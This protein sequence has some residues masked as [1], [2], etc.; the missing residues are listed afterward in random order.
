VALYLFS[1]PLSSEL[2]FLPPSSRLFS[3]ACLPPSRPFF[4]FFLAAFRV[5]FLVGSFFLHAHLAHPLR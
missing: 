1:P 3:A 4:S 5:L 2:A